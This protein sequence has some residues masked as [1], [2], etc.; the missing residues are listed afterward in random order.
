MSK[1]NYR[2]KFLI[3]QLVFFTI[4]A[5]SAQKYQGFFDFEYDENSGK[6]LLKVDKLNQ[7]FLM[8]NAFGTGIGSNDLGM[9][10]GKLGDIR[11]VRFEK[12]GDKI[13]LV[14]P[15]LK[16]RAVSNNALEVRAVEEA[17]AKS[18]IY[19]FK[20]EKNENGKFIIDLSSL[21]YE[22]LNLV[23]N[24]LKD[25]KQGIYKLDKTKSALFFDNIHAFPN[26]I[27]LESILTFS[28]EATGQYIKSVAPAPESVS[29]RQH[30]SFIELPDNQ[31]KP[32]TFHP[33]SG[34][35]YT[36]YFDYATPIYA[37]IEKKF[38]TRHRL[39]KKFPD[40]AISEPKEP[41]IY[42]IDPGCPEPIKS[43]LMEGGKWW[44]QAFEAA[45]FKNAF[46]VRELPADA[47]PLDVRY[48]MI[49]WVH[50]STRGWSYG[51]SITDP[52]TGEIIK[53]HV[54]LGSLRVR[55]DFMIAQGIASPYKN[56]DDNHALMIKMSLDRLRQLSAHEIG[57]TI[58]LAHNF[59]AST[60]ERASVMD[61]PHPYITIGVDRIPDFSRAYDD[62]IGKWDKR[63]IQYGYTEFKDAQEEKSGLEKLIEENHNMG[64]HYLTDQD[65]RSQGSASPINH[66]W[67]NGLNPID[68]FERIMQVRAYSMDAFG[69]NTIP[70]G[71]PL[72][73]LE[74][75]F[76]PVYFL[77]RYQAEAVSKIIGGIE[78]H[79]AVKGFGKIVP[80]Q[81]V[82][83][84]QQ[85]K[86][87]ETLLNLMREKYLLI[88][89]KIK[90]WF[91]PPAYGYERTRESFPTSSSPSFD[92]EKVQES[93]TGQ[94]ME[95]ILQPER[96]SRISNQGYLNKYFST[97]SGSLL[98]DLSNDAIC[99]TATI[100]YITRLLLLSVDPAVSNR[101]KM[102]VYA[103]LADYKKEITKLPTAKKEMT[104]LK[105]YLLRLLM[106]T[107]E[108]INQI[109]PTP[110][111]PL[112]PGA[113]IGNCSLD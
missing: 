25:N 85:D 95:L 44:A 12:H 21:M 13:L 94:I 61:Y 24:T 8:V 2:Q 40:Q 110:A 42:Y 73:E 43:A 64:L 101:V 49:Q 78:Y 66:L 3:I 20:I 92:S 4:C 107:N 108:E 54:T 56:D 47:H 99:Q 50:R 15:N 48:N 106:L 75:I 29:Y 52:R 45:G 109:K 37:P 100:Q 27:E 90:Q 57:H 32:R 51:S 9:D 11:I 89:D 80:L 17:F 70:N 98:K 60:N 77:H 34:Y 88:P 1:R 104:S 97:I 63:A 93:A 69:L 39:E 67:D 6:L 96:L 14:Q 58:G 5:L 26:N 86:A 111:P 102:E 65:A 19:G 28:G 103:T 22:D 72:S 62:K 16:F 82:P 31:Y 33:E 59:A 36:S 71:T 41:I 81:P 53:G 7:D 87:L 83:R 79:Y 112:P 18:V 30:I 68:E 91:Y 55:Q 113:P 10:R 105:A 74:K 23:V 46:D 84:P 38:I 35:F 76:V